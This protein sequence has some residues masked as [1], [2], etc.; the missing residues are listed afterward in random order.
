MTD[1]LGLVLCLA[2][3]TLVDALERLLGS[4]CHDFDWERCARARMVR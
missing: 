2:A 3:V 4:E 1:F